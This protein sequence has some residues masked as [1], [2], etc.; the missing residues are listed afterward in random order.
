MWYLLGEIAILLV[1]AVG[2]GIGIGW[3][4]WRWRRV[5][6]TRQEFDRLLSD[7]TELYQLKM[8]ARRQRPAPDQGPPPATAPPSADVGVRL[9]PEPGP[10]PAPASAPMP[11]PDPV[12]GSDPAL[13]PDLSPD[14]A[15]PSPEVSAPATGTSGDDLTSIAGLDPDTARLLAAQGITG[16]RQLGSLTDDD[17]DRLEAQ[18]PPHA[19]RFRSDDWVGQAR[20]LFNQ[21]VQQSLDRQS[22]E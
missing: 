9:D 12:P 10:A 17:V 20:Q 21:Q 11:E 19:R 6:V 16:F 15:A 5:S 2:I 13:D 18:L 14:L 8:S 22:L 3:L 1:V 4:L 7:R